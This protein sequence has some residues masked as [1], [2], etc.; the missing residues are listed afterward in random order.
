MAKKYS[1]LLLVALLVASCTVQKSATVG[2]R[3]DTVT[4]IQGYGS[5]HVLYAHDQ[6]VRIVAGKANGNVL[7]TT[8]TCMPQNLKLQYIAASE[9]VAISFDFSLH[10]RIKHSWSQN[11]SEKTLV[12]SDLHGRL[13]AFVALLKGNG[14]VDDKLHWCYGQNQLIMIG[15]MLD[16]GR[17]DNGI[18]WLV[19]KLE[20]EA[21]AV[22]GRV[23]FLP[24]NHE[25]LVLKDDIRYVNE[26]NLQF[27][28]KAG[29][30]YG[31]LYGS[32]TELGR[33]IRDSYLVLTVGN[34]LFVHA[35]L[36]LDLTKKSYKIGEINELAWR[37]IGYPTK[38]KERLHP[39][40]ELLFGSSGP[41]WYRGLVFDSESYPPISSDDLD[42]VLRYYDTKHIIVGH[43]EVNEVDWRYDGRV[44]A[45]NVRHYDN[46]PEDQTAGLLIENGKYYSV[47][48]SG[49]KVLLSKE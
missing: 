8:F 31:E 14:V 15:D 33:W 3:K 23:D 30:P 11:P 13:D 32:N 17:D 2:E 43:S 7:D 28:T 16:R 12:V 37:F 4:I 22:G 34:N 47:S 29:I 46:Y 25:D 36:S 10:N 24:G 45:V 44:I 48:Y 49:K 19:Y 35:G 20:Q 5:L 18:A 6:S 41:L 21:E 40:N 1:R 26:A 27:A 9:A 38:E 39:R 42:K